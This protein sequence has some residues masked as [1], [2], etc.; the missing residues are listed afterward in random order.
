MPTE[1]HVAI[2]VWDA[3]VRIFHWAIVALLVFQAITGEIGGE[4]VMSMHIVSGYCILVLVIF[5]ILWGFAGST[6][7]RFASF[8]AGPAATMRF[9]RRL[10]SRQAVPQV[11]HN[12]LGGWSV[13]A[14][15]AVL[16]AQALS[17]LFANDGDTALGP[18]APLVSIDTS[19][20]FT[21]F[22]RW[23]LKLLLVLAGLHVLA[24]LF[25]WVFKK[26]NLIIAMFTGVKDVPEA[27]VR[28]R[29]DAM[30][31][32]PARRSASRE[33]AHAYFAST[34]RAIVLFVLSVAIV[35]VLVRFGS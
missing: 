20:A 34:R 15:I 29:R 27:A 24:V 21:E 11:G 18:L 25:H 8:L 4:D 12:P 26:D 9:A 32:S 13:V 3:P 6:H 23:N 17:G 14:M 35:V 2:K 30:R 1:N 10:F 22:H 19:N 16:G 28:E 31:K 33:H 7:A 5:R